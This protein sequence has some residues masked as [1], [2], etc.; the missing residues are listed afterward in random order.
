M[1]PHIPLP[2]D[3][4]LDPEVRELLAILPPLNV[5]RMLGNAPSSIK[6]FL[7]MGGSIL[8]RSEFDARK[9]EIA[10]LRVAHV[11]G[12]HYVWHQ[13]VAIGR[14]TGIRNEEIEKI[15][16]EGPVTSLDEEGNLLCRVAEEI[17]LDVRLSDEALARIIGRYGHRGATELILCCCWFNL[18]ARF[19]ESTR[20][21]LEEEEEEEDAG[22]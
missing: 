18:V 6:E 21:K 15:G 1:R 4:D 8:M 12:A 20:V 11:T 5:F 19:T 10:I 17:S 2:E 16:C 22:L 9:R 14:T 3:E 7:D 13:H